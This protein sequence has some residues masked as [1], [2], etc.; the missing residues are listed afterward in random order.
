[1]AVWIA[2]TPDRCLAGQNVRSACDRCVTACPV[3]AVTVAAGSVQVDDSCVACGLC[4]AA[5]PTGVFRIPGLDA[6]AL[7]EML[8]SHA[9]DDSL[10]VGC[11]A[12][13][14]EGIAVVPCIGMLSADVLTVL[15]LGGTRSLSLHAGDCSSCSIGARERID[16]AVAETVSRLRPLGDEHVFSI[17][18]GRSSV[19]ANQEGLAAV[20]SAMVATVPGVDRRGFFGTFIDRIRQTQAEVACP[21]RLW[22]DRPHPTVVPEYRRRL[23]DAIGAN[24][25]VGF[26]VRGIGGACD[27]CQDADPLCARFCPSGAIERF[28]DAN[29]TILT[30]HA[31]LCLA[32][33][34][35]ETVCPRDA[36]GWTCERSRAETVEIHRVEHEECVDCGSPSSHLVDGRC[37][38]CLR[39]SRFIDAFEDGGRPTRAGTTHRVPPR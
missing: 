11:C 31:A 24:G 7:A 14:H 22:G 30:F 33:G 2:T 5:C 28:K 37:P 26:R 10:S 21:P 23:L 18:V 12:A 17:E 19:V 35:C 39:V 9:D 1:M 6:D 16:R 25:R 20:V 15:A 32:C 34:Q 29:E 36:V 27:A 8:A 13:E 3:G 38:Q 4:L